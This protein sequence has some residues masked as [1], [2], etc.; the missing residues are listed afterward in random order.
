MSSC[1]N[2]G[3][4]S[5]LPRA[6][7]ASSLTLSPSTYPPSRKP[8]R[9]ASKTGDPKSENPGCRNP[10]TGTTTTAERIESTPDLPTVSEASG[11]KDFD[12]D[13]WFGVNAPARTPAEV[14]SQL[15]GWFTASLQTPDVRSKLAAQGLFGVGI[16]GARYDAFLRKQYDDYGRAIRQANIKTQ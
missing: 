13:I 12:V 3:R 16:C 9:K 7:R 2:C 11:I 10:I 15:A 5:G 4:S 1:V 8:S 6:Q 14:V